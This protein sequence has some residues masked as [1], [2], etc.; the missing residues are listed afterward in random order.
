MRLAAAF[1]GGAAAAAFAMRRRE[2]EDATEA[3]TV[4]A[5][6]PR[7]DESEIEFNDAAVP[8]PS[9]PAGPPRFRAALTAP[10]APPELPPEAGPEPP[11]AP[12]P[13]PPEPQ[14]QP[15]P[16][17]QP[18]PKPAAI[19]APE[20]VVVEPVASVEV[21]P[22]RALVPVPAAEPVE[23]QPAGRRIAAMVALLAVLAFVLRWLGA[24]GQSLFGDE[25][26]SHHIAAAGSLSDMFDRFGETEST[27]P[28]FYVLAWLSAKL[29]D[30][31]VWVR[32]PSALAGA[33]AV[34]VVYLLGRRIGGTVAG[35]V[36]AALVA[37]LPFAIWF[38]VEARAYGLLLVLVPLSTLAL[39][40][41]L[42][43]GGTKW[44]VVYW[45]VT[46]LTLYT[47]YAAGLAV[48]VQVV[49]ALV[50]ARSHRPAIFAVNAAVLLAFLPWIPEVE[51][52]ALG[53]SS[54]GLTLETLLTEPLRVAFGTPAIDAVDV[55]GLLGLVLLAVADAVALVAFLVMRERRSAADRAPIRREYWLLAALI[56]GVPLLTY[57]YS[58][59]D[60]SIYSP[61]N[62]ITIL[63]YLCVG[64]GLVIAALPRRALAP[65]AT[66][67]L[68]AAFV[69]SGRMLADYPRPDLR[70][71]A[72]LIER[73][74]PPQ[75]RVIET[76]GS[77][78]PILDQ[79]L[80]VYL[81][82]R[83]PL[84]HDLS[85]LAKAG[86][87]E[88]VWVVTPALGSTRSVAPAAEA[89]GAQPVAEYT[90][91]GY[92]DVHVAHYR[93]PIPIGDY[94]AIAE[95]PQATSDGG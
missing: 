13:Q 36:A 19:G 72:D 9:V 42:D 62:L 75:T 6:G 35:L 73:T 3:P 50:V 65:V 83:Y 86:P 71:A 74:A 41:G 37:V 39:L 32:L 8:A 78:A 33:A 11:R 25:L 14:P 85:D 12:E 17:A 59:I 61:R 48:A 15:E 26:F 94:P 63:P 49:W 34:A 20:M 46:T 58:A 27:P 82:D 60:L 40:R 67:L 79:D 53:V 91:G 81:D 2:P 68:A 84:S 52:S 1:V 54:A 51:E 57:L 18:D 89:A 90:I 30:A 47:H 76:L 56:A 29:G 92:Q 10:P 93:L 4:I 45:A 80:A 64:A 22:E 66:L 43:G 77:P 31:T 44:W 95:S 24:S 38:G 28:V 21:P 5:A 87:G 7:F 70:T 55:P 69:A 88:D 16:D 23:D